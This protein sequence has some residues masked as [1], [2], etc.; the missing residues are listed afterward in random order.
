MAANELSQDDIDA[1]L[2]RAAERARAV[3][4]Q[5]AP[6]A[7]EQLNVFGPQAAP[8]AV[9]APAS[10]PPAGAASDGRA[11]TRGAASTVEAGGV[12]DELLDLPLDLRVRLGEAVMPIEEI[13]ALRE[14]S[15]I[16]L[17]RAVGD[18]VDVL[19]ND[20]VVAKGEVVI[21]DDRFTVRL[22]EIIAPSANADR[23]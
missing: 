16:E 1:L 10:V 7:A 2:N 11:P 18:P 22:T 23:E 17:D 13:V 19:V 6:A 5:R 14:G 15:V 9:P 3:S 4:G 20:T 21:V 12:V 8:E